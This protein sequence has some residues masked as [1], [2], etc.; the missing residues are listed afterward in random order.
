MFRGLG[1]TL[2]VSLLAAIPGFADIC[3]SVPGNF[4]ANC[5]F[6]DGVYSSTI[7][8]NTNTS[9]PSSWTPNAAYDLEPS[10]NHLTTYANSGSFGLSIGNFD[11]QPVPALS[12]T[13]TDLAGGSY[14]GSL[15][16]SYGYTD[17]GAYFEVL[18]DG[19]PVLTLSDTTPAAYSQ[20]TF[21]FTG[22]G[23]DVLTI[24]GDT[25]PSEWFV[26]DVVVTGPAAA[27]PEPTSILL[28]VTVVG[29]CG[30]VLRKRRSSNVG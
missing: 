16:V 7:N 5:G 2:F 25:N 29:L 12:Q 26:D 9:V 1:I 11:D 17:P 15:Y 3:S 20:Y 27:T 18:I 30:T 21:S 19:A 4:V 24:E 8:G 10:F 14:S 23:S 22:T 28:L 6:E 13:L